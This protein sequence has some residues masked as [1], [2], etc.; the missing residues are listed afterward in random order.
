MNSVFA[1]D[2]SDHRPSKIMQCRWVIWVMSSDKYS[3]LL[4]YKQSNLSYMCHSH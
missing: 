1:N 2:P 4:G 3:Y